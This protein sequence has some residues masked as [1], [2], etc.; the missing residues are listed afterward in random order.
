M[1]LVVRTTIAADRFTPPPAGIPRTY[2]SPRSVRARVSQA[3][4]RSVLLPR[5]GPGAEDVR[6][7]RVEHPIR[8]QRVGSQD[9]GAAACHVPQ[10]ERKVNVCTPAL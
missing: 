8:V 10:R 1:F 2:T 3:V 5:A 9:L 4:V 7:D 6:A